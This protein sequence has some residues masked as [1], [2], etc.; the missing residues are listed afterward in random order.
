M[1]FATVLVAVGLAASAHAAI[2]TQW[3][4]NSVPSDANTSTGTLTPNIGAGTASLV[5][6]TTAIFASGDAS[7]GS[8]DPQ[9]GDDSGWGTTTY[10]AQGTGSGTR[11]AQYMV[12][13]AGVLDGLFVTFDVRHSNTSSRYLQFEYTLDA[14]S[15]WSSAG[16][17]LNGAAFS[18]L[19]EHIGGDT[20]FNNRRVDLFGVPG[21]SN[22]A[23]FGFRV[24]AVF[25]PSTTGYLSAN[26][27]S[28][29][30][31]TGTLRY[32]MVTVQTPAPGVTALLA[33]GGLIATRR[34][35]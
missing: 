21:A 6:G 18:G 1:R 33:V 11:G 27:A 17:S 2:V 22:N 23:N 3:N 15:S 20:W 7:G 9:V 8:T 4:F 10:A 26:P 32:D 16:L 5:G 13:T 28:S 24:V 25:A 31:T 29:Y 34:R 12:S 35:R 14:G 19:F 30:A